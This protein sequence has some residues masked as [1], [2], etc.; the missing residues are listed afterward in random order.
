[1]V[2]EMRRKMKKPCVGMVIKTVV[3]VFFELYL[4]EVYDGFGE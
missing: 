3:G 2:L 4:V 1:V